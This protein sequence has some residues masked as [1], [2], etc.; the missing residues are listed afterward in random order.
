MDLDRI[1]SKLNR[2]FF[3]IYLPYTE[4][5]SQLHKRK[6]ELLPS[7]HLKKPC[8]SCIELTTSYFSCTFNRV[9]CYERI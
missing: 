6:I 9:N 4:K 2:F 8:L 7:I 3:I 5:Q 1:Y